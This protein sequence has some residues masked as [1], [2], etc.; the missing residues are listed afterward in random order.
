MGH[1]VLRNVVLVAYD[2]AQLLDLT[3]PVD[4]FDAAR[5]L[6][7]GAYEV[8][9]VSPD[10]GD[11]RTSAGVVLRTEAVAAAL[12]QPVDTVVVAGTL[13]EGSAV[14]D[15]A[16]LAAVRDLS[17]RARR[18]VA[19]CTGAFVLAAIGL[20]DGRR[21]TTHWSAAERLAAAHPDV[22]VQPERLVV[23]DGPVAT[24]G[25]VA[26]GIDLALSLVAEDHG[27]DLARLVSKWLV[28]H[29]HRS[30]GQAPFARPAPVRDGGVPQVGALLQHVMADPAGDHRVEV[31]AARVG[32][33][34]RHLA[35][36]FAQAT[37]TT[38]ARFVEDVRID[39]A[40]IALETTEDTHD[41]IA[42][43]VGFA[44]AEV[45]RQAFQRRLGVSPRQHR[46]RFARPG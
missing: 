21:A 19:V 22:V 2:R 1:T 24:S 42:R 5:R 34:R 41:A 12:T 32:W 36:V 8:S 10:G 39:A 6:S 25:G 37:G 43:R 27:E 4:V 23:R 38:P 28:V 7:G 17:G 31:L 20:L 3:G 46:D 26:S 45:M 33:S 44:S 18:T 11:V 15:A 30:G 35:R 29:L 14:A 40:V 16:L 9:L 13:D